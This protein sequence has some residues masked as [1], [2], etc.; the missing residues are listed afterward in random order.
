MLWKC[1]LDLLKGDTLWRTNVEADE[2]GKEEHVTNFSS[3]TAHN[4]TAR[5]RNY[6]SPQ[7]QNSIEGKER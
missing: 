7:G 1:N 2:G 5:D 6:L 4:Q 3:N